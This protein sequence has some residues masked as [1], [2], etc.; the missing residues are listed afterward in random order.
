[1]MVLDEIQIDTVF[2][3]AS[4]ARALKLIRT[5]AAVHCTL[6]TVHAIRGNKLRWSDTPNVDN[7][8]SG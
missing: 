3:G 8:V 7:K 5:L 6:D 1:M 2:G 4:R